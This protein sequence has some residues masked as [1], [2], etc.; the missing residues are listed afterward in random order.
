MPPFRPCG[1]REDQVAFSLRAAGAEIS[2][3]RRHSGTVNSSLTLRPSAR[4]LSEAKV[5]GVCRPAPTKQ[6]RLFGHK[7]DVLLVTKAARLRMGKAALADAVASG[8]SG[9]PR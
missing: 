5:V 3:T 8:C 6:A 4:M 9:G 1:Q 2:I 7:P